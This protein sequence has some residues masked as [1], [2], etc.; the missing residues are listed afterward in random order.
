VGGIGSTRWGNH[1]KATTVEVCTQLDIAVFANAGLLEPA[2][3]VGVLI[4]SGTLQNWRNSRT[5]RCGLPPARVS[6]V[7]AKLLGDVL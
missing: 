1:D 4:P 6:P 5:G 2:Q 7:A 3:S